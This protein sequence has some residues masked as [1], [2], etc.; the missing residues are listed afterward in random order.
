MAVLSILGVSQTL[1]SP[2]YV[3]IFPHFQ[4]QD[5][6]DLTKAFRSPGSVS[7]DTGKKNWIALFAT[8]DALVRATVPAELV[9]MDPATSIG[10]K[11]FL[12]TVESKINLVC[13]D[14][15]CYS[16]VKHHEDRG[17]MDLK[18]VVK[19]DSSRFA[20]HHHVKDIIGKFK[21]EPNGPH[22]K[23]LITINPT[24]TVSLYTETREVT[25]AIMHWVKEK[26]ELAALG[27]YEVVVGVQSYARGFFQKGQ[28]KLVGTSSEG[29]ESV[30]ETFYKV[31]SARADCCLTKTKAVYVDAKSFASKLSS[32]VKSGCTNID[33]KR[34]LKPVKCID[35]VRSMHNCADR[36]WAMVS[37][38]IQR[39]AVIS[40]D[41]CRRTMNECCRTI[42]EVYDST[43]K[44]PSGALK[45]M[46]W[47]KDDCRTRKDKFCK[48]SKAFLT[49]AKGFWSTK[50]NR[51]RLAIMEPW[52]KVSS[53][54]LQKPLKSSLKAADK[55]RRGCSYSMAS[56]HHSNGCKKAWKQVKCRWST[57]RACPK[58]SKGY[59]ERATKLAN[60]FVH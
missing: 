33:L 4:E 59:F 32:S 46:T 35:A 34:L 56:K 17:V 43:K 49:S 12:Q 50:L 55:A 57:G 30:V 18:L 16:V 48:K 21:S 2:N 1:S 28:A 10:V 60:R 51:S 47:L 39:W 42:N 40:G 8:D 36:N 5:L 45:L 14:A 6:A 25:E 13:S 24:K 52:N 11:D 53:K 20:N 15:R 37:N 22:Q 44:A 31:A 54:D 7:F 58:V 9:D 41:N 38:K 19:P 27:A 23:D 29:E 26:L 3:K